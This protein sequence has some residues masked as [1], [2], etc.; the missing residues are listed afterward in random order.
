MYAPG[1]PAE[2]T[3][4]VVYFHGGGFTAGDNDISEHLHSNIGRRHHLDCAAHCQADESAGYY[5]ASHRVTCVLATYRLLPEARFP[6]GADDVARCLSWVSKHI[7]TFGGDPHSIH[8]IGQSAGGAHLATALFG[9][10]RELDDMTK[11]KSVILQSVPFSYDL[12]L[13]RRRQNMVK[14]YATEQDN[15]ILSNSATGIFARS[16]WLDGERD[17]KPELYIMVAQNDSDE[18][19][20]ANLEFVEKYRTKAKCLPRFEVLAG[21]NHVSYALSIGLR[22]DRVG[23]I[24]LDVIQS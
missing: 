14:Y 19:V 13:E 11:L 20:E 16:R 23:P 4:V 15:E 10:H 24:L 21:H 6:D 18:I 9:A 5:F 3:T 12:K 7:G 22:G 8:A 2:K 17:S 1:I